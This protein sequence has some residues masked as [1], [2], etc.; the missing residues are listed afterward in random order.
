MSEK[1]NSVVI[2]AFLVGGLILCTIALIAFGSGRLFQ[3]TTWA[4]TYFRGSVAGLSEGAPVSFR[5]VRVGQVEEMSIRLDTQDYEA[6][7]RVVMAMN[8]ENL[9]I[10]SGGQEE[11]LS[12]PNLVNQGLR[13]QLQQQSFVTGQLMVQ[14]DFVPDIEGTTVQTE[15]SLPQVPTVPSELEQLRDTL[16]ELPLQ[17][18][19]SLA[20]N[21]L[22]ALEQVARTADQELLGIGA[23]IGQTMTGVDR[24]LAEGTTAVVTL[25]ADARTAM[26]SVQQLSKVGI[27]QMESRGEELGATLRQAESALAR[28]EAVAGQVEGM[29]APRSALR[30]DLEAG[31]RDLSAA[32]A[33][34]RLFAQ[35]VER[36]PNALLL[37]N[38]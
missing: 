5:G 31:I 24:L 14:L 13:A 38:R 23:R 22:A 28:I 30:G 3:E 29:T 15:E 33:S 35:Q 7:I 32:A 34:L 4:V 8:R 10:S 9:L 18:T 25:T 37:G 1:R 11:D 2:G 20:Q 16:A 6:L 19:L 26:D 36:N 21:T 17:E 12:V 27:T